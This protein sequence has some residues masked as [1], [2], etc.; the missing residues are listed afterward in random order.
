M[1]I[2]K[3]RGFV[4]GF[5]FITLVALAG[6]DDHGL[7]DGPW[8]LKVLAVLSVI[9]TIT[10]WPS[11]HRGLSRA[12]NG[13]NRFLDEDTF[14]IPVPTFRRRVSKEAEDRLR[15]GYTGIKGM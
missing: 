8:A 10:F 9:L 11:V 6:G 7:I 1:H 14:S 3:V 12:M 13:L 15:A 5:S 2:S 4:G